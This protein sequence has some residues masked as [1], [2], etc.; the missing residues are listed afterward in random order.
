MKKRF[1]GLLAVLT[2][3]I[4]LTGCVFAPQSE[5]VI[6]NDYTVIN[7]YTVTSISLYDS[8]GFADVSGFEPTY[9]SG[10]LEFSGL[11]GGYNAE[12]SIWPFATGNVKLVCNYVSN[13]GKEDGK[14][15]LSFEIK[16][17]GEIHHVS[18]CPDK[19]NGNVPMLV[20]ID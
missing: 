20:L 3:F 12:T 1:L 9:K 5:I 2:I 14:V 8:D 15:E 13:G 7:G 10:I 17:A 18:F 6:S 11:P 16:E 19:A 4:S